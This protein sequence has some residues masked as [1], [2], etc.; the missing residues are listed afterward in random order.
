MLEKVIL[1]F[2]AGEL[3][4]YDL[5]QINNQVYWSG[6]LTDVLTN[7]RKDY[8]SVKVVPLEML[9]T[10]LNDEETFSDSFLAV[11]QCNLM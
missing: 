7:L 9:I 8:P 5:E 10:R 3:T 4:R 2:N 6:T 11:I 1:E